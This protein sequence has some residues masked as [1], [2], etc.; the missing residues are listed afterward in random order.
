MSYKLQSCWEIEPCFFLFFSKLILSS[1][2]RDPKS[3]HSLILQ[4]FILYCFNARITLF[5]S[6]FFFNFYKI[7]VRNKLLLVMIYYRYNL[8]IILLLRFFT[9]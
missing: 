9:N 6:F 1:F 2:L 3:S 8:F 7:C 4:V 5:H